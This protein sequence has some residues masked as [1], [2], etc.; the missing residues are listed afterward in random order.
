[1][2]K[3]EIKATESFIECNDPEEM[4]RPHPGQFPA[5]TPKVIDLHNGILS[6]AILAQIAEEIERS[7]CVTVINAATPVHGPG[8]MAFELGRVYGAAQTTAAF[9]N[10]P[11]LF[12][13]DKPERWGVRRDD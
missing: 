5:V 11:D 4:C 2:N 8:L 10:D 7:G 1:M 9:E 13:I 12:P 3:Q 6:L